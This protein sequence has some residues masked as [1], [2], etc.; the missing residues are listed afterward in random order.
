[1]I[2]HI[3]ESPTILARLCNISGGHMRNL[4]RL[5]YGCLQKSD[6]P[7]P[8]TT[9]EAVICDERD[10]LVTLIDEKEWQQLFQAISDA[11][12]QGNEAYNLLLR[13]LFL[14]EYRDD[15]GR[16]FALNP[17]LKETRRYQTWAATVS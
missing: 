7:F 14:Y 16:W 1:Q 10:A 11:D 13:S 3:F 2:A 17:V 15:E 5:L 9:L 4:M 8:T 6:P 12:V